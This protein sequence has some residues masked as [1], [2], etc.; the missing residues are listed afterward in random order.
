M[1]FNR[2]LKKFRDV[3]VKLTRLYF[4]NFDLDELKNL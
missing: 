4:Q 2:L 3:L 1:S